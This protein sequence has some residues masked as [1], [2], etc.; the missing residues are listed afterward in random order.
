MASSM[1]ARQVGPT[2]PSGSA[3][4]TSPSGRLVVEEFV[5]GRPLSPTQWLT[6]ILCFL[7]V[8][9][10]GYDTA[11]IGYIAPSISTL[12]E[13]SRSDLAPVL[14]ASLVGVAIGALVGGPLADR[15]GRKSLLIA[16]AVFF[17]VTSLATAFVNDLQSLTVLRFITGI[18]LGAAIPNCVTLVA[19]YAPKRHRSL[20]VNATYCGFPVGAA[21]G[22]FASSWL[23]PAF[24]WHSV[25]VVGGVVP[26]LLALL[27]ALCVPESVRY[28]VARGASQARIRATLGRIA[29]A[30]DIGQRHIVLAESSQPGKQ[31]A[32]GTVLSAP[33]RVGS[34][35]LWLVYFM[36]LVIFYLLTS[37][38]PLLMRDAGF[39]PA[40]AAL[41]TALFPLG[42]GIGTLI[43]GWLM[44]R[45]NPH[46]VVALGYVI[47]AVFVYLMGQQMGNVG[48]LAVMIFVAGTA[49]NGAQSSMPSLAAAFYPTDAR[50]TGVASMYG[51]GR[52]GGIAG[53]FL[54]GW[55]SAAKLGLP[56][57]FMLLAVPA[58]I[59]AAALIVK[60]RVHHRR[61]EAAAAPLGGEV[62]QAR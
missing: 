36:G 16:S 8:L 48:L 5:D 20:L 25:L 12:W 29:K 40:S 1:Q 61:P 2:P 11:A 33:Y 10:D 42:G 27:V 39:T 30:A 45:F 52:F 15:S 17:G 51:V 53:V 19:E 4:G 50:A 6:V 13:I 21:V 31:S 55:F 60:W 49:M 58:L 24:G 7:V 37:W 26:I 44:D 28:L 32:V 56:T 41:L 59:A 23:I 14:S 34:L 22:G 18:G 3:D 35:M 62:R 38:M 57:V 9:A 43:S 47:T 54:G 46:K